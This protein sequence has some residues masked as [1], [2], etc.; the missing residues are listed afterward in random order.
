MNAA[1]SVGFSQQQKWNNP[2]DTL[3]RKIRDISVIIAAIL[4]LIPRYWR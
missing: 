3:W 4:L 1:F 2:Q